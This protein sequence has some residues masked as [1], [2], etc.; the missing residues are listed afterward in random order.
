V[1]IYVSGGGFAASLWRTN[2]PQR[3]YLAAQGFV[4]ASVEYRVA[5]SGAMLADG[6]E[7]VRSAIQWLTTNADSIG[8]DT[9]A[10]V[11][12][13]GE[14]AGAYLAVM[15]ALTADPAQVAA[16]VNQ[17]GASDFSRVTE[18]LDD[19][20]ADAFDNAR[21]GVAR[22]IQGHGRTLNADVDVLREANPLNH[23]GGRLPAF[24]HTHG[25]DDRLISPVQTALLHQALQAAGAD[26][27]RY[28]LPGAGHGE[29]TARTASVR[30]WTSTT[31]LD[32][33]AEFL[34]EHLRGAH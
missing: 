8:A 23:L 5:T 17:F 19:N 3:S 18:G 12:L 25:D 4:V 6:V 20:T 13:W 2:R 16:V 34:R 33:Y 7:D 29:L 30:N 1:V 22:Y 10:G 26:S 24:L 28:V 31:L 27:T 9:S 21:G 14:S 15:T 11:G 32:L